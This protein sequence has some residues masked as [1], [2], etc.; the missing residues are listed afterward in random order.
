MSIVV[1]H[2]IKKKEFGGELSQDCIKALKRSG[3]VALAAP[4]AG[5]AIPAKTR[6]LKGYATSAKGPRR[7]VYLLMVE[8]GTLFLLFFRD[9][10]DSI[11][12]NVS[13]QNPLFVKTL[14]KHLTMLE[15]DIKTG[16]YEVL[17]TDS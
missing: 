16:N 11:G 2:Q 13:T 7:V 5:V 8:D 9:K 10:N 12:Q 15:S 4:I 6:L 17:D 3:R 1:S 14:A